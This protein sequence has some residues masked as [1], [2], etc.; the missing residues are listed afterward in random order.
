VV[1]QLNKEWADFFQLIFFN[2]AELVCRFFNET[3]DHSEEKNQLID[4]MSANDTFS[5]FLFEKD[6]PVGLCRLSPEGEIL[7]INE[8]PAPMLGYE[9]PEELVGAFFERKVIYS[10]NA[11]SNFRQLLHWNGEVRGFISTWRKRSGSL[12]LVR[13]DGWV[14]PD[15]HGGTL[16]Y[17]G[18]VNPVWGCWE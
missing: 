13:E 2:Y 18:S 10:P 1:C 11:W 4:R 9:S 7:D 15:P 3:N 8:T 17:E 14:I 16:F 6:A 12:I 5:E